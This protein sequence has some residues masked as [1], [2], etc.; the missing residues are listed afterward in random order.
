MF[1]KFVSKPIIA[2]RYII[3]DYKFLLIWKGSRE[4]AYISAISAAGVAYAVTK[5]CTK[6]ELADCSCDNRIRLKK[7]NIEK[8][9][10][11]GCSD[12]IR[13]GNKFSKEFLDVS[14]DPNTA[15]GLMN[16]HNNEA[17]RRV[18]YKYT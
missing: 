14:E 7:P 9:K 4:A 8:W 16:L 15:L 12:D 18:I 3:N 1:R 2:T 11:G 5:A 10:W 6:G 17:G 13:Y